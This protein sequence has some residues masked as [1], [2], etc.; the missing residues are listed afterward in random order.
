MS[1]RGKEK[2][3]IL[4]LEVADTGLGF[5][6]DGDMGIGLFNI[7]ERLQT[8]YGDEGRLILEEERTGHPA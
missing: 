3:D 6:G 2:G 7:R 5:H 1:I 4:R 8:L